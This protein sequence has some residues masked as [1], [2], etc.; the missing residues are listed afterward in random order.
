MRNIWLK[1]R[2]DMF[3]RDLIE[4]Y[5]HVKIFFDDLPFVSTGY[6]KIIKSIGAIDLHDVP[7]YRLAADLDHR[8]GD[9]CGFLCKSCALPTG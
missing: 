5:L 7:D 4:Q 1:E 2:K 6:E 3:I 9:S 8:L